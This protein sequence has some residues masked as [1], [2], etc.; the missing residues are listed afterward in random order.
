VPQG[1]LL[2]LSPALPLQNHYGL[3]L[4]SV[5]RR[6]IMSKTEENLKHALAGESEARAK[7]MKWAGAANKEGHQAI[8]KIFQETA[9]NEYEHSATIMNLLK[10]AGTTEQNLAKAAEGEVHEWTKMYPQFAKEAREEGNEAAARYFENVIRIEKH[11]GKRFKLLLDRL[12]SG[13]LYKSDT[14]EFWF[15]TNCGYVHK[16]KEAPKTCPNCLHPVG[17][18][19][20][21]S[22]VD[23]GKI[24]L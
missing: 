18:F 3:R 13:A 10:V 16:G 19:K 7:Y 4:F 2:H 6:G 12:K 22:E 21:I 11:H 8:G 23:Y 20:R 24:E 15:C 17:Y 5:S 1:L 9:E 14:E